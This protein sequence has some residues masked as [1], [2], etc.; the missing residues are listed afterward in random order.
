MTSE[1]AAT[2]MAIT[3]A[4]VGSIANKDSRQ[5][6]AVLKKRTSARNSFYRYIPVSDFWVWTI[7]S[8]MANT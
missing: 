7:A 8:K 6:L 4:V 5:S 2:K 3:A 1:P